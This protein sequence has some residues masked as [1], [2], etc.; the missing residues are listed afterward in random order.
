[1]SQQLSPEEEVKQAAQAQAQR[2]TT[3]LEKLHLTEEERQA[4]VSVIPTLTIEQI[5]ELAAMLE[6]KY[7]DQETQHV[8]DEMRQ[9]LQ[10]IKQTYDAANQDI[11]DTTQAELD[12]LEQEIDKLSS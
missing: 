4:F 9:D 12:A 10:Q 8:D 7:L 3:L 6:H 5:D 1:M 11:T 2:I